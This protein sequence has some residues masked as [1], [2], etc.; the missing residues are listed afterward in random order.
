MLR[1]ISAKML[2]E[3]INVQMFVK[4]MRILKKSLEFVLIGSDHDFHDFLYHATL[5]NNI[6]RIRQNVMLEDI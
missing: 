1:D 6:C 4:V 2:G 3:K 5:L